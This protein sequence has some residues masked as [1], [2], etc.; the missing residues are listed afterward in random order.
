[1]FATSLE[2]HGVIVPLL[3]PFDTRGNIDGDALRRFV[4]QLRACGVG[5]VMS[6]GTTG[7]GPLLTKEER[8]RVTEVVVEAIAGSISVIAQVGA[9]STRET[10][11]LALHARTVGTDAIAV[12]APYFYHCSDTMLHEHYLQVCNAVPDM[13]VYLYNIPQRTG[14][15]LTPALVGEIAAR[16]PNMVGIKDSAGDLAVTVEMRGVR[17]STFRVIM[18]S[19][20]L[21]LPALTMGVSASVSGNANVFPELFVTLFDAFQRGDYTSARAAQERINVVRHI[22]R[23]GGDLALFKAVVARRGVALGG[24][25]PPLLDVSSATVDE[26]VRALATAGIMIDA[27]AA[28][29]SLPVG[30]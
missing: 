14:N 15:A 3:T 30:D 9:I 2:L 6:C 21:I 29:S 17:E 11:A 19:D 12:V 10:I 23:D 7:E 28:T 26:C 1:M 24:V 8:Q 27:F 16:C 18:G 22:L 13:P 5:G 25:R 20:G 4:G